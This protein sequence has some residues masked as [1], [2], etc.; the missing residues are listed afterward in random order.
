MGKKLKKK[1]TIDSEASMF[2][3]NLVRYC[4]YRQKSYIVYIWVRKVAFK[5]YKIIVLW[6]V[7]D[8]PTMFE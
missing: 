6:S 8:E 3:Q 2:S 5:T 4:T 7:F 1:T